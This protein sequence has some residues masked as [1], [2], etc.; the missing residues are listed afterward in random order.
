MIIYKADINSRKR[1]SELSKRFQ[2]KIISNEDERKFYLLPFALVK[3]S[4]WTDL[5]RSL[6][7]LFR[8]DFNGKDFNVQ[9]TSIVFTIKRN[10]PLIIKG[11][12]EDNHI[13]LT[14]IIP[15][16]GLI[17][18]VGFSLAIY[19]LKTLNENFEILSIIIFVLFIVAYITKVFRLQYVLKSMCNK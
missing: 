2:E 4:F 16:Y 11:S 13:K 15:L 14:Y 7:V 10:L 19:L 8:G 9:T 12:I 3:K 5:K 6:K 17:I 1:K 18:I